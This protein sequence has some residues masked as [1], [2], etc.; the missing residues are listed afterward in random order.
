MNLR[1]TVILLLTTLNC[2]GQTPTVG[3]I[4]R[5]PGS[6]DD[7]YVLFAPI[8][9]TT[10]YLIDK[11]G[12]EVHHWNSAYQPGQSVYLLED[13]SLLRSGI[14]SNPV[15]NSGGGQGGIIEKLDW[16]SNVLWSYTFSDSVNCQ[17]H[18]IKPMPNGNIL[19][20]GWEKKTVAEAIANGRNP[21]LLGTSLWSEQVIELQPVGTDSA[22]VVWEW[23]LWDHLIQR[24]DSTKL[25]YGLVVNHPELINLNFHASTEVDWIHLNAVD[26]NPALD[27]VMISA[28]NFNEIWVI[29]HGTT[30]AQAAGHTGGV[31]GKGGDLL[32]RWGNPFAYVHGA[33]ADKKLF[34]QHNP[35]W[36]PAG[37]PH[38]GEIMVFNNGN[39]RNPV[40]YSSVDIIAPPVDTAGNYST[41]LPFLPNNAYWIYKDSIPENFYSKNISGAQQLSNGNVLICYGFYGNF[42]EIDSNKNTVWRYINPVASHVYSQGDSLLVQNNVFR[43]TFYPSSYAGFNGHTLL[44]GLPMEQNPLPDNCTLITATTENNLSGPLQLSPNPATDH[45]TITL[46]ED[47][48]PGPEIVIYNIFGDQLMNLNPNSSPFNIDV[49]T[50]SAGLY[51]M[52]IS[53]NQKTTAAKFIVR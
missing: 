35:H 23:H 52:R 22:I 44:P 31:R 21:A 45:I 7:G 25:N 46:P 40:E 9:S 49:S 48:L 13:G 28:H 16:N 29:D 50:L 12:R 36:I 1:F 15:F 41:A 17:H 5:S 38:A 32:W 43:C 10:T 18:D 37:L 8:I 33:V 2:L 14:V 53:S 19:V 3:L 4:Q 47:Y 11:C 30:T 39:L 20:I 6:L 24:I 42:F 51:L 26:Y 34:M 27:Q